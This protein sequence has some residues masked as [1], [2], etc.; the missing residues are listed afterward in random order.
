MTPQMERRTTMTDTQQRCDATDHD[1]SLINTFT[2]CGLPAVW[3][4]VN[5]ESG[6]TIWH[7][8]KH[9]DEYR[10]AANAIADSY[11]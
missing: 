8:Q 1:E 11:R 4:L 7:C 10:D 5:K 2:E 6:A 3:G 9:T